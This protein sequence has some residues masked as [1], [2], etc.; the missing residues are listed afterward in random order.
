MDSTIR[1]LV[2]LVFRRKKKDPFKETVYAIYNARQASMRIEMLMDRIRSRRRR[3]LEMVAE[4]DMRGQKYLAKRYAQEI[5]K[6]DK[7][8]ARLSNLHLVMEK[9][10]ASLEY[11]LTMRNFSVIARDVLG[12]TEDIKKLPESTIP[13]IGL[14]LT[15]LEY[16][17]RSVADQASISMDVVDYEPAS[18]SEVEKILEEARLIVNRKLVPDIS[19]GADTISNSV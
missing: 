7:M 3:L 8:Y 15:Q 10:S 5:A 17:L 13:D 2:V 14:S 16:S 12:L 4:L 11:A 19:E 9:I 1:V 6:L 18:S